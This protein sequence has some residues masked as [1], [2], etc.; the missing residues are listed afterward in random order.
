MKIQYNIATGK[1]INYQ[2]FILI[3]SGVL[4]VALAF[5]YIGVAS[6]AA[7]KE[8]FQKE[9]SELIAYKDEIDRINKRKEEYEQDINKIK[10]KWR[11]QLRFCN[12]AIDEKLFPYLEQLN[13]LEDIL[14]AGVYISDLVLNIENKEI[15]NFSIESFSEEK[16]TEAYEAFMNNKLAI[17]SENLGKKDG[18]WKA[19][20]AIRINLEDEKQN[21]QE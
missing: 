19:N 12:Q 14:P 9:K 5:I 17:K 21:G 8:R 3:T 18:I 20:L 15:V 7:T 6:L 10:A 16:L 1:K 13:T 2:K 11:N 4:V